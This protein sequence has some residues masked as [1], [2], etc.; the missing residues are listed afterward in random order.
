MAKKSLPPAFQKAAAA[1]KKNPALEKKEEK[2]GKDLDG[3]GEKGESATHR[4]KVLGGG[5]PPAFK[6]GGKMVPMNGKKSKPSPGTGD[7]ACPACM[8]AGSSS[9]SHM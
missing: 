3:D 5:T 2:L 6:Q 8:K 9:C 1:K 7:K 4:K